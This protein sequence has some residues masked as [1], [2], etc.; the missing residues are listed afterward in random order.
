MR[1]LSVVGQSFDKYL[2]TERYQQR[3]EGMMLTIKITG[4]MYEANTLPITSEVERQLVARL[5][6][7]ANP[8]EDM[9]SLQ[10]RLF[11]DSLVSGYD[12]DAGGVMI[13]V[14]S[15]G[16]STMHEVVPAHS[17]TLWVKPPTRGAVLVTEKVTKQA[18]V[19]LKIEGDF[20][21]ELLKWLG[22][23]CVLPT[24]E[25]K[26]VMLPYYDGRE[27]DFVVSYTDSVKTYLLTQSGDVI[28]LQSHK[29]AV[30]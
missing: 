7:F 18:Q 2:G 14:E 21:P 10:D 6:S 15:E 19:M 16:E 12:Q 22:E 30:T 1:F 5:D 24:T 20:Q 13:Q 27:F 23:E 29:S 11:S 3:G 17:A 28:R 9:I 26:V 25:R 8:L 4:T